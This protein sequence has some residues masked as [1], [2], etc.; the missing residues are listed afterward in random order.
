MHVYV[1]TYT[2]IQKGDPDTKSTYSYI[3][4][5]ICK[6][7]YIYTNIITYIYTHIGDPDAKSTDPFFLF[8][9]YPK[10]SG[11]SPPLFSPPMSVP[12]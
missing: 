4:T 11:A 6:S 5:Y 12:S 2:Y 1:Y 3:T 10:D 9:N 8:H 7:I